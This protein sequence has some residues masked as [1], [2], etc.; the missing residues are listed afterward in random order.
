MKGRENVDEDKKKARMKRAQRAAL[1]NGVREQTISVT[2]DNKALAGLNEPW[3]NAACMGYC[4]IAMRRAGVNVK[5]QEKVLLEQLE[6]EQTQKLAL[7]DSSVYLLGAGAS[8]AAEGKRMCRKLREMLD[9][10]DSDAECMALDL[11]TKLEWIASVL[12]IAEENEGLGA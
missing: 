7:K 3:S 6:V 10:E 12:E 5:M 9:R 2:Y 1:M 4:L 11:R 8:M